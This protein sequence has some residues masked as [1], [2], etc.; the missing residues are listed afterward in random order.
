MQEFPKFGETF[1]AG[2]NIGFI[3][4]IF[5]I[6]TLAIALN[7][8]TL[9]PGFRRRCTPAYSASSMRRAIDYD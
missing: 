6:K 2:L 5:S 9:V 1:R 3:D 4:Q 8:G 7:K